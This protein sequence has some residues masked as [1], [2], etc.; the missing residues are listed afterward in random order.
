MELEE[1]GFGQVQGWMCLDH[2]T[3]DYLRQEIPE[4][5][6][7]SACEFCG[8]TDR[9]RGRI[10]ELTRIV[11]D[12][13]TYWY[14][15]PLSELPW[16][17]KEGG[18]QGPVVDTLEAIDELCA[19]A[20]DP[21]VT[22]SLAEALC[23]AIHAENWTP[24]GGGA[25]PDPLDFAWEVYADDVRRESRF[26]FPMES[27]PDGHEAPHR[28]SRFL[29]ELLVYTGP[30][31]LIQRHEKG[32]QVYRGRLIEKPSSFTAT[33]AELGPAPSNIAAA[34]RMSAAGI[35][36]L[37]ASED[38]A[39]AISEIAGHGVAPYAVVG[40]FDSTRQLHILDFTAK[41][42]TPGSP[43]DPEAR[44]ARRMSAFLSSFVEQVTRAIIPDGRQHIQYAPTQVL[45]EY[46]RWMSP[47]PIDGI[48]LP[49]AQTGRKTYVFF[50]D[51]NGVADGECD[52]PDVL[53]TLAAGQ[54]Q[55][56]KVKRTY[57]GEP[58]TL[59]TL[60]GPGP[61]PERLQR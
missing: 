7:T 30:L 44:T 59:S 49:S 34:N 45:T 40:R 60:G 41:P 58:T 2:L 5:D 27:R 36:L 55:V 52:R 15:D 31:N 37:Y 48:A 43:F 4:E 38:A 33:A 1:R 54:T 26:V 17:G 42:A 11:V 57:Q 51:R 25:D 3:D 56:F 18:F 32:M 16:D 8:R 22:E 35:S 23:A 24:W 6:T 19:E 9:S 14:S 29:R 39:T 47:H 12:A 46:F 10:D 20:F 53:F 21:S 13:L 61:I 28:V 50:C